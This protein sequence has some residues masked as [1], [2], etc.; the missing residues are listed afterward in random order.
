MRVTALEAE[1]A[2]LRRILARVVDEYARDA[3]NERSTTRAEIDAWVATLEQEAD[4][5]D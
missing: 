1:N 2:R 4:A 3:W 5:G